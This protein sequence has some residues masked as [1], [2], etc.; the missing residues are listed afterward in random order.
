[1]NLNGRRKKYSEISD[2][3]SV[4]LFSLVTNNEFENHSDL[5][6]KIKCRIEGEPEMSLFDVYS[7][8]MLTG[9]YDATEHSRYSAP[10]FYLDTGKIK[11]TK[12][13]YLT[14]NHYWTTNKLT[15]SQT[16][17]VKYKVLET[18]VCIV[19]EGLKGY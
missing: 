10:T 8:K 18:L 14:I 19:I 13:R 1:M 12:V 9:E 3:I 6:N 17:I 4:D 11:P 15:V 2:K 16:I 7:G 5:L